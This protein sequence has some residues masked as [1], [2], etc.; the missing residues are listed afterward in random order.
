MT[1]VSRSLISPSSRCLEST[2][3]GLGKKK[4]IRG[5]RRYSRAACMVN[6]RVSSDT[7]DAT[8][9]FQSTGSMKTMGS[10]KVATWCTS[11][12][13]SSLTRWNRSSLVPGG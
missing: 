12:R 3:G 8:L 10:S 1:V 4:V 11:G 9:R 13:F 5:F 7:G 6:A 2:S